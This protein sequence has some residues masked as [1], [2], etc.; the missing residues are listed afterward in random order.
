MARGSRRTGRI[1]VRWVRVGSG[2]GSGSG[3]SRG[4]G[5]PGR[6]RGSGWSRRSRGSGIGRRVAI[7]RW[8]WAGR[9]RAA[10][11]YRPGGW[12][13]QAAWRAGSP[14]RIR[15]SGHAGRGAR[16]RGPGRTRRGRGA[17]SR[18]RITSS[19]VPALMTSAPAVAPELGHGRGRR[20]AGRA[21]APPLSV[22]S[23]AP[24]AQPV[25]ST[26]PG[27]HVIAAATF[28]DVGA[29]RAGDPV[30]RGR[31]RGEPP[32]PSRARAPISAIAKTAMA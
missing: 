18:A 28:D 25:A 9:V 3:G 5:R 13:K 20:T 8:R 12:S 16:C 22:S 10:G 2:S 7:R 27:Q 4:S 21:P 26:A 23:A 11:R 1:R 15:S 14:L 24:T 32:A 17:P 29:R 6:S 31:A 30:V 19:P